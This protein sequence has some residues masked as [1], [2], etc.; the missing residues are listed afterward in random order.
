MVFAIFIITLNFYNVTKLYC[1][2]SNTL[3]NIIF[4]KIS[5]YLICIIIKFLNFQFFTKCMNKEMSMK[6]N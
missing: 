6:K 2:N 1:E 5:F 4:F 3:L